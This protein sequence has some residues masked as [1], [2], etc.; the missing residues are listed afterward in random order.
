MARRKAAGGIIKLIF[1]VLAIFALGA[2]TFQ[3]LLNAMNLGLDLRGGVHVV[4]KAESTPERPI[5]VEDM[6]AL[7]SI[8]RERVD[9]LGISEPLIQRQGSDRLI[10]ELAGA[11][12]PEEAVRMIGMTAQL[13]FVTVDDGEVVLS[14][15]DLR[16]AKALINTQNNRP[17]IHLKFDAEGTK[18]FADVTQ[19]LVNTYIR[20]DPNRHIAILL[21]GNVLT[22]PHVNDVIPSG[23]AVI[24]G[25]FASYE[26]AA[27]LAAL[28]RGG[29]LPVPVEIIELRT[30]GP[31]LGADSLEKSKI[32]VMVGLSLIAL[33]MLLYYRLPG[34]IAIFSLVVYSVIVLG[35]LWLLKA[36]LTLPAIAG[37]LLSVGMAVDTNII[38]YERIR[39]ELR[40]GKTLRASIDAGFKRAFLTIVDANITTIIAAL[41][42]LV[43]AT[44]N[45]RGFGVTLSI[46]I[47]SSMFTAVT[48]TRFLLHLVIWV[49]AFQNTWLYGV[50]QKQVAAATMGDVK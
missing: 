27:N 9:Q 33:F 31:T 3:P 17:E 1:V 22:N 30:V 50:G 11:D 24:S 28:L 49:P 21:D 43:L 10:I 42:L 39:E 35:I 25:G 36:T 8:M 20:D 14:G 19:R 41:V 12:N 47:A 29:A 44:G 38:I 32:A 48:L 45:V 4:M 40:N 5:Q 23:D 7:E 18:K 6:A 2:G 15:K 26:E 34:L 46:G 13:E 37:L 16:D